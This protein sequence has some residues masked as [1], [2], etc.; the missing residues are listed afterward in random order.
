MQQVFFDAMNTRLTVR[1]TRTET[2]V[3]VV[4]VRGTLVT[5]GVITVAGAV[6]V[7]CKHDGKAEHCPR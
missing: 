2:G 3:G 4:T 1:G 6:P 7:T 5:M